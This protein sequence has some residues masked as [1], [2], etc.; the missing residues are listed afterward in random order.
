MAAQKSVAGREGDQRV[1]ATFDW[2]HKLTVKLDFS[3]IC[4][5][6]AVLEGRQER[7]GGQRNGLYHE[8]GRSNTMITLQKAEKG[9][10]YLGLSR[11]EKETGQIARVQIV[12]SEAESIGLRCIF[13]VGLFFV[14]YHT[15]LFPEPVAATR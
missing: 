14:T 8:N 15:H 4:E 12:L 9:G 13:Q 11:K 5:L 3:D 1:P 6:L 7:A 10:W 2:E